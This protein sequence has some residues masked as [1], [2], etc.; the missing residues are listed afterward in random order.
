M[1]KIRILVLGAMLMAMH[2]VLSFVGTVTITNFFK[3][4]FA[5]L[6]VIVAGLMM[7]PLQAFVIGFVGHMIYQIIAYPLSIFSFLYALAYGVVG[8][9]AGLL[10]MLWKRDF[11]KL[12]RSMFRVALV[13]IV[14]TTVHTLLNTAVLYF[15]SKA[16]GWYAESIVFGSLGL[17]LLKNVFLSIGYMILLPP[18]LREAARYFGGAKEESEADLAKAAQRKQIRAARVRREPEEVKEA[19][20]AIALRLSES[21][22]VRPG[23]TVLSY[24]PMAGEADPS[25]C[26]ELFWAEGGRVAYPLCGEGHAMEFYAADGTDGLKPGAYGIREPEADPEKLVRP[27]EADLVIVPCVGFDEACGRLGH[28]GGYYDRYL[29]RCPEATRVCIAYEEQKLDKVAADRYDVPMDLVITPEA[30]YGAKKE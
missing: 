12:D 6:P 9:V 16:E 26:E 2:T 28:G 15:Q 25:A 29:P 3:F 4:G 18:V 24:A 21:V 27:E 23:M 30:A 14:T 8:L 19:A 22:P 11:S 1:K 13:S 7:G 17:K 5:T 10:G 20:E